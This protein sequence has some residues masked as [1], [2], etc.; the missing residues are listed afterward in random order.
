MCPQQLVPFLSAAVTDVQEPQAEVRIAWMV[1][2]GENRIYDV[3][4]LGIQPQRSGIARCQL[5]FKGG[6]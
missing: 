6:T 3:P 2:G 4:V 1:R 5:T